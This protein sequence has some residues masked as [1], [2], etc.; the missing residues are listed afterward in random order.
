MMALENS[1]ERATAAEQNHVI[2]LE[3]LL[4]AVFDATQTGKNG[5][6][7]FVETGHLNAWFRCDQVDG[8]IHLLSVGLQLQ[9]IEDALLFW[10]VGINWKLIS[11]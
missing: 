1:A 8:F 2:I 4:M 3:L 5:R 6:G 11:D 10:F 7:G 9:T